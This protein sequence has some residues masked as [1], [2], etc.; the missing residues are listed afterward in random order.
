MRSG[1]TRDVSFLE[2]G[3]GGREAAAKVLQPCENKME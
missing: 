3:E 2:S 1:R